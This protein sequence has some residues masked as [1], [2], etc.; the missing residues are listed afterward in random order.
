MFLVVCEIHHIQ[1]RILARDNKQYDIDLLYKMQEAEIK[2][3]KN[4]LY[5]I[6]LIIVYIEMFFQLHVYRQKNVYSY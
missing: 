5:L 3:Y 2:R 6:D 4:V 1:D